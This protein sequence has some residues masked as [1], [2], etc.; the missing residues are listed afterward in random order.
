MK[1]RIDFLQVY[2]C[3]QPKFSAKHIFG[4]W[5]FTLVLMCFWSMSVMYQNSTKQSKLAEQKQQSIQSAAALQAMSDQFL[6]EY[7]Q[8]LSERMTGL[9]E[10]VKN[11]KQLIHTV[12]E[13]RSQEKNLTYY[14]KK[15]ADDY[16]DGT[17]IDFVSIRKGQ[18]IKITGRSISPQIVPK[19]LASWRHEKF[20]KDHNMS[21]LKM[22]K[23]KS[24]KSHVKFS[25]KVQ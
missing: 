25:I 2:Q 4:I 12:R 5:V 1:Q 11:K 6:S 21:Y 20:H 14:V 17:L 15:I 3:A 18:G 13:L 19:V 9:T 23:I 22:H 16:E 24:N 10:Q 7:G 8:S